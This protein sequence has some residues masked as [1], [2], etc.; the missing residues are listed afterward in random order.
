[1]D[2]LVLNGGP[3]RAMADR[4]GK[5]LLG[6]TTSV[7]L[8]FGSPGIIVTLPLNKPMILGRGADSD[9]LLDLSDLNAHQTGVSR[10]HCLLARQGHRLVA[11]DLGSANGTFLNG[12]QMLPQESYVV[13]DGDELTFGSLQAH[14]YFNNG[15]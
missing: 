4:A 8:Q 7:I 2:T 13:A 6:P 5:S 11:T 14:V 9:A 15:D 3:A 10:H 12:T 1:M